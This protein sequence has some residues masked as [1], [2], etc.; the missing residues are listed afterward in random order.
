MIRRPPRS[1]RTDTLFPYTTLFRSVSACGYRRQI[2]GVPNVDE[3]ASASEMPRVSS[4]RTRPRDSSVAFGCP[5]ASCSDPQSSKSA[6]EVSTGLR[7]HFRR[8]ERTFGRLPRYGHG[9]GD[10]LRLP[11]RES[12]VEGGCIVQENRKSDGCGKGAEERYS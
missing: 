6:C 4:L 7:A 1:T 11:S 10:I 5:R 2:A 8:S 12:F 3:V 9:D